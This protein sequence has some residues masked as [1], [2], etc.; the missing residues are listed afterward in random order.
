MHQVLRNRTE[1]QQQKSQKQI[2]P[3]RQKW[4]KKL[5]EKLGNIK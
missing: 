3:H 4:P 5:E 2:V 1:Q